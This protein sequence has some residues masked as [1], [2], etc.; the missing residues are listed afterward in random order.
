MLLS[1]GLSQTDYKVYLYLQT[2]G[3]KKAKN[4]T[5]A[6]KMTKQQLYPSLKNLQNKAIIT[7]TS[8]RPAIYS[9]VSFEEVIEQIIKTKVAESQ[10]IKENKK[11][12]LAI[13]HSVELNK[14]K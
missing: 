1:L 12:L 9:A 6:L 8:Q 7:G 3:S 14:E 10:A 5:Q 11:E 13:W 2:S 4:I